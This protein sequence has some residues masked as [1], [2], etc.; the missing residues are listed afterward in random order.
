MADNDKSFPMIAES[1]WWKLRNLFL[2]KVPAVV[3]PGYIMA[4]F[5]MTSEDS[6]KA[7]IIG[8]FKKLGILDETGKPTDLAYEWRDDSKYSVVCK[9]ILEEIYPRE[10][11]DLYHTG[12]PDIKSLSAW[13]MHH[14]RCGEPAAKKYATLYKLLQKADPSAVSESAFRKPKT[15]ES[16]PKNSKPSPKKVAVEPKIEPASATGGSKVARTHSNNAL[17]QLHINI[18]LHIS[19]ESSPDQID[20]IF[21]SMAKHLKDFNI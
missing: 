8:P 4:A 9:K 11:L 10:V 17:P 20:K 6:A 19:P 2:Q 3:T 18:Q 1:N 13:F 5:S 14:C 12:E 15:T 21:E 16:V 7:N